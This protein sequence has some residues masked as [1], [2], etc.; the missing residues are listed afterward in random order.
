MKSEKI[1]LL[2][3]FSHDELKETTSEKLEQAEVQKLATI[4]HCYDNLSETSNKFTM[5]VLSVGWTN[6]FNYML[7]MESVLNC[8]EKKS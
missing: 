4:K 2:H 8:W 6:E 5:S 3:I 7:Y 1:L